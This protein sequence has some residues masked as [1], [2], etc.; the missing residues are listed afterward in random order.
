MVQM[1]NMAAGPVAQWQWRCAWWFLSRMVLGSIA[2][3]SAFCIEP[4]G[5]LLGSIP[6]KTTWDF[7]RGGPQACIFEIPDSHKYLV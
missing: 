7:S 6:P 1:A 4:V 2:P 3:V 5:D